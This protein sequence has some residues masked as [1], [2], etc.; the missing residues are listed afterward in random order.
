MRRTRTFIAFE[1]PPL[2]KHAL[3]DLQRQ[4][5]LETEGVKWVAPHQFHLTLAFLGEVEDRLLPGLCRLLARRAAKVARFPLELKGLS[6]F[7]NRRRPKTLWAGVPDPT[8]QL[9]VFQEQLMQDLLELG[10][11]RQEER[12]YT[13]HITLGR[14]TEDASE[15]RLQTDHDASWADRLQTYQSWDGGPWLAET[16]IF[17]ASELRR[18]GPEHTVLAQVKLASLLE[19]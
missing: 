7:P 10:S 8:G 16:M 13:P 14:I 19:T 6:A 11:F 17:F 5:A 18:Q 9:R 4:L 1:L 3:A 2:Q 15:V 12:H